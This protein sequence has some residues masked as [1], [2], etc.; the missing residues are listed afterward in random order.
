MNHS[1]MCVTQPRLS[2]VSYVFYQEFD[3]DTIPC[4]VLLNSYLANKDSVVKRKQR[5]DKRKEKQY[6]KNMFKTKKVVGFLDCFEDMCCGS[7]ESV[8]TEFKNHFISFHN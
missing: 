3:G 7:M 5:E 8:F 4:L 1:T 6:N 2:T